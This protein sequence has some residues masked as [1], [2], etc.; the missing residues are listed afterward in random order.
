M[1]DIK[2]SLMFTLVGKTVDSLTKKAKIVFSQDGDWTN[3]DTLSYVKSSVEKHFGNRPLHVVNENRL[4]AG[5]YP[6]YYCAGWFYSQSMGNELVLVD[7][8]S[9]MKTAR[10]NMMRS[11]V[12]KIDWTSLAKNV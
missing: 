11:I 10:E 12:D 1:S 2:V 5:S 6:K 8:G 3:S 4:L 7:H 9:D